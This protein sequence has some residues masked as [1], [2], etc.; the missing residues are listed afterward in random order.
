MSA[1]KASIAPLERLLAS[2][3]D[4]VNKVEAWSSLV[5]PTTLQLSLYILYMMQKR[6]QGQLPVQWLLECSIETRT[7]NQ[8]VTWYF[9]VAPIWIRPKSLRRKI[10]IF[11]RQDFRPISE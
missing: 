2:S 6:W 8:G 3:L 7:S 11:T 5:E 4:R 10:K 1:L 9:E